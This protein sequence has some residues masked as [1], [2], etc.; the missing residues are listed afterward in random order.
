MFNID[1]LL[2]NNIKN[3]PS[4][5]SSVRDEL[6]EKIE[7][8]LDGN[9]NPFGSPLNERFNRYPDSS[10]SELKEKISHIKG[11]PS[12]NIFLGNGSDEA[13]DMLYRAFCHPGKDSVILTPPTSGMYEKAA[14]LNDVFIKRVPLTPAF[15]L[16]LESISEV[17]TENTKLIFLCSPNYPTGNALHREDVELILNNFSGLL[18]IDEAFINYS[19]HR[20][21]IPELLEYPNL[22]ILQTFSKAWGMA[23]L[24]L[25]MAF[26]SGD[27]I[28]V[29]NKIRQSHNINAA[30]Q[31]YALKALD[32]I[33]DVN[34]W[35]K[36]TVAEREKM[37]GALKQLPF[38]LH[39]F[40]SDANF[41]LVKFS[42]PKIIFDQLLGKGIIIRDC[43]AVLLCEDCL[44]ITIGTVEENNKLLEALR[45]FI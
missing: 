34:A 8:F 40:P 11:V 30:T 42:E 38:V 24:R 44:Q 5:S 7:I 9:E 23:G 25:A 43:S 36:E 1:T 4:P 13:I 27:I 29:F 32:N 10:Q 12:E 6:K 19:R 14:I 20:S 37:A 26:A 21:F 22:V 39:V 41:L 28:S 18:V 16:D 45:G 35:T 33:G 2:R 15:Q 3:L 31:E 17:V